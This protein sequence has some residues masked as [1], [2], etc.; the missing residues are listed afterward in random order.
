MS[1]HFHDPEIRKVLATTP[2]AGFDFAP[3]TR[4]GGGLRVQ[5]AF[6]EAVVFLSLRTDPST[7]VDYHYHLTVGYYRPTAV[8]VGCPATP[9]SYPP[10]AI[11]YRATLP[12]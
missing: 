4:R 8:A 6:L 9:I 1:C 5:K 12:S 2:G 7:A 10:T 3:P 11:G